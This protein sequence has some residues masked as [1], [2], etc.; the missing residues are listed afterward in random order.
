MEFDLSPL[1]ISLKTA[2]VA[3]FCAFCRNC[4]SRLDEADKGKLEGEYLMG[5]KLF[6]WSSL[7]TVVGF[8]IVVHIRH[9]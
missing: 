8:F 9:Q 7:L 5:F 6:L 3:T 1:W 2:T 4:R